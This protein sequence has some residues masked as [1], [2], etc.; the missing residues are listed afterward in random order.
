MEKKPRREK[1]KKAKSGY[2]PRGAKTCKH[3]C[4]SWYCTLQSVTRACEI[5]NGTLDM[6]DGVE[7]S[8]SH[9]AKQ[10]VFIKTV[11]TV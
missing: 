6:R 1:R 3:V 7:S 11:H 5:G 4:G 10:E 9:T 8:M 2:S